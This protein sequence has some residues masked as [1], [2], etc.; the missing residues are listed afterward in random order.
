MA[1]AAAEGWECVL[2]IVQGEDG[3]GQ[4]LIA[5]EGEVAAAGHVIDASEGRGIGVV[6]GVMDGD[7]L[8]NGDVERLHRE[9]RQIVCVE[10]T[11]VGNSL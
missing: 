4:R 1:N 3:E 2:F 7:S 6:R 9:R 8:T 5:D 11:R 10:G